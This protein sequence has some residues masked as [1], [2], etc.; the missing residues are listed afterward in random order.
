MRGAKSENGRHQHRAIA[1][2]PEE[3]GD[4]RFGYTWLP[5]SQPIDL[6]A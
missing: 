2:I 4:Q 5:L 1:D 3:A 6:A